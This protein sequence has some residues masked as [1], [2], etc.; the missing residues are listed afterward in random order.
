MYCSLEA[1]SMAL[2]Q[3]VACHQDAGRGRL[4]FANGAYEGACGINDS[5]TNGGAMRLTTN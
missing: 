4:T 2:S 1:N 5:N 3:S